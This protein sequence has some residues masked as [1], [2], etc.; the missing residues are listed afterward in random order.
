MKKAVRPLLWSLLI[1]TLSVLPAGAE[2]VWP[3]SEEVM[4]RIDE[5]LTRHYE[6]DVLRSYLEGAE[7]ERREAVEF[8]LAW[9][10]ASD[11]GALPAEMLIENVELAVESWHE[12]S[13]SDE[14]DPY[15]FHTYV[16]PHRVTQ[17]PVQRWR[18]ELRE[19][20]APRVEGM[21]L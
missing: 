16:L 6:G 17:E 13:W 11:L 12:A 10:P 7:V 18:P 8:L 15:I 2:W 20:T 21:T 4:D 5:N 9:L 14:I 3:P 1:L 19:L